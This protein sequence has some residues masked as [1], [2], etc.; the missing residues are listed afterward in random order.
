MK[1]QNLQCG[2]AVGLM[3]L[4]T[5]TPLAGAQAQ[6]AA[7]PAQQPSSASAQTPNAPTPA[8]ASLATTS[9]SIPT[10][11]YTL[12]PGSLDYSQGKNPWRNPIAPFTQIQVPA[13]VFSNSPRIDDLYRDGKIYLSLDDAI[14]LA[15]QSNYDVAIARYNLD[16]ADTDLLRVRAGV[17]NLGVN[18]G[19]LTG[20]LGGSTSP[21][22][23]S[24]TAGTA[25]TPA[26]STTTTSATVSTAGASGGGPGGTS[27]GA[28]GGAS[29]S[30]GVNQTTL[31]AGPL[32]APLE[33]LDPTF[34]GTIQLQRENTPETSNLFTGSFSLNQ[35]INEY[36]FTYNQG[37]LYGEL[38]AI[39]FNNNRTTNNA[40]SVFASFYSPQVN[41]SFNAQITQHLLQGF[42]KATNGRFIAITKNNRRITD[43]SFRAQLLYTIDQIEN[44]YWGLV[45]AYEDEQAKVGALKQSMQLASDDQKQLEIG[46]LAP[47]DVVQANANVASD[48]QA[49]IASQT[50]LEYQQLLMKQAIARNLDDPIFAAAPIIPTDRISLAETPEEMKPLEALVQDAYA[51]SPTIEQSKLALKNQEITLKSVKNALLPLLDVYGFY[52][53]AGIGGSQSPNIKCGIVDGFNPCSGAPPSDVSYGTTLNKLVNS[54][55][56]NKGVGF[57]LTIPIRNRESQAQQVRAELEYRQSQMLLQQNYVKLRMNV[58]NQLYALQNDRATVQTAEAS[59]KYAVQSLDAEQKKYRLGA[60]TTANV[61]LQ[62]RSLETAQ[63]NLISAQTTYAVDRAAL[64]ELVADTLDK[65]GISIT[66]AASGNISHAPQVPGLEAPQAEPQPEPLHPKDNSQPNN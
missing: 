55:G 45:G 42:G 5:L 19:L 44:I 62:T 66:E 64:S 40:K 8:T 1:I 54:S 35:N 14:L 10:E 3:L 30:A 13:P 51:N 57:N 56:S 63:D 31:G 34:T 39:S 26:G 25:T 47:L 61:L 4:S 17:P 16:I 6:G 59:L 27:A 48:K 18:N 12:R 65:Y 41:S 11:P 24:S 37:F 29:G 22:S 2:L 50:K 36:N 33:P 43:S 15:L 49:L 21:V 9:Q 60:S 38:L 46:T 52:G 28:G 7:T 23:S 53:G 58:T 20:T 32:V